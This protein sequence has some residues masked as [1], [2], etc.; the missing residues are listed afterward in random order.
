[1]DLI[2][3]L[4]A[5]LGGDPSSAKQ[6]SD[7]RNTA[8]HRQEGE[9][10]KKN[11]LLKEQLDAARERIVRLENQIESM[12]KETT[13]VE[14]NLDSGRD[15]MNRLITEVTVQIQEMIS[16]LEQQAQQLEDRTAS[17]VGR[18]E[19]STREQIGEIRTMVEKLEEQRVSMDEINEKS[20]SLRTDIVEKIHAEN[21]QCYRNMKSLVTDLEV[22][23]EELELGEKSLTK[24]RKS[25]KGMKFF[26][27]F[28]FLSFLVLLYFL[29]ANW[30]GIDFFT[31]VIK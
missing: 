22:K 18:M 11:I 21:V 1:M 14:Q 7:Q 26:S 3:G 16:A 28:S 31:L 23:I 2:S 6:R 4:Q 8:A 27:F 30:F 9:L 10:K 15:D 17:Q 24:I 13:K 25:F 19:E 5:M 12:K 20:E 29:L